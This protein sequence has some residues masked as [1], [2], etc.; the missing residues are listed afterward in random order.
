[1]DQLPRVSVAGVGHG[2]KILPS[3]FFLMKV[4]TWKNLWNINSSAASSS[5]LQFLWSR[6]FLEKEYSL[7]KQVFKYDLK[8]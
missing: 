2:N 5:E 3:I 4:W 7:D 1:M 8:Y 6:R